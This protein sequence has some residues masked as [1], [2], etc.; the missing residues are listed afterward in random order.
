M[1]NIYGT[2]AWKQSSNI[3][4]DWMSPMSTLNQESKRPVRWAQ[5]K[6]AIIALVL[7]TLAATT[8]CKSVESASVTES[9]T[10]DSTTAS[11]EAFAEKRLAWNGDAQGVVCIERTRFEIGL[12]EEYSDLIGEFEVT[13]IE[14][15]DVPFRLEQGYSPLVED[16]D[17]TVGLGIDVTVRPIHARIR[18]D[19]LGEE[20]DREID[21]TVRLTALELAES[22]VSIV[23]FDAQGDL[24]W[25]G[26]RAIFE[27]DRVFLTAIYS[28]EE[29]VFST[30]G[31]PIIFQH[32]GR[33]YAV[34]GEDYAQHGC[35]ELEWPV[36]SRVT[37]LMQAEREFFNR[38]ESDS[39]T[40]GAALGTFDTRRSNRGAAL[41][42]KRRF[43][44][45]GP[46]F[47]SAAQ[48]F[49]ND[50]GEIEQDQEAA[51]TVEEDE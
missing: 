15:A 3:D 7:F 22:W 44:M 29:D 19:A 32:E 2:K 30:T 14:P 27:G 10:V 21:F 38:R 35:F 33:I 17:G 1:M 40:I 42:E 16:C 34:D 51:R 5:S 28:E 49:P 4:K 26:E 20:F 43:D 12:L 8:G 45:N 41:Y 18:N 46:Y 36:Q 50:D 11:S 31:H 6:I 23:S 13:R 47:R 9:G 48:C 24:K 25:Y 39:G 37:D